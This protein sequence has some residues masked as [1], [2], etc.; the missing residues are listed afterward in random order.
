MG[1][2]SITTDFRT[3]AGRG[4]L[5]GW[6]WRDCETQSDHLWRGAG[7]DSYLDR[8]GWEGRGSGDL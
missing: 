3:G 6:G 5:S 8:T 4:A 2:K 1:D 7:R